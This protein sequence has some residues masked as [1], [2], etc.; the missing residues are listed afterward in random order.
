MFMRKAVLLSLIVLLFPAHLTAETSVVHTGPDGIEFKNNRVSII[1]SG[2]A[3]LVAIKEVASNDDI[4]AHDHAKIASAIT[5]KGQ[6]IY[7]NKAAL[8][9]NTLYLTIGGVS[10]EIEVHAYD[11][12]FTFEVKGTPSSD[13]E[14]LTFLDFRLKYN[15]SA[16]NPLLGAGVALSLQTDPVFFPSGESKEIAGRCTAH[17]GMQGAKLAVIVCR[18][19][20]LRNILKKVYSSLPTLS[21]PF[22]KSGGAFSKDS[23]LNEK[24]CLLIGDSN[25]SNVPQ[26]L[27]FYS[28]LGVGQFDFLPGNKTFIQGDFTFP[29]TGSASEFKRLVANPLY[30]RGIFSSLHTYSFY[31]SYASKEILGNPHWQQQLEQRES[32]SLSKSLTESSGEIEV[33]GNRTALKDNAEYWAVHSPYLLI[34]NEIIKYSIGK[35]GFTSC[36]RGQCGTKASSHSAGSK[37]IV[38]GGNYSHFAPKPGSELFYEI[39][40][41]TARTYNDGGFKG[42]YFDALDGL[43]V[44]LKYAGLEDYRWYYGASFVNEVLKNCNE[45]PQVEYSTLYP[46]IWPAR[47]RGGAWDTPNRGYKNFIDDHIRTNKL[48]IDRHY[49]T[50]LGW[51]DFYPY[52]GGQEGSFSTKYMF[53]DDVDYLGAKSIAY[54]QTMTYNSLKETDVNSIPAMRRNLDAFY[55]Y[56][57]LRVDGYFSESVKTVLRSGKYEYK[58]ARKGG[59]WGFYEAVYCRS[60]LRDINESILVGVNPFKRQKPFI[61]IEN[62]YSSDNRSSRTLLSFNESVDVRNQ[63]CELSFTSPIDLSKHKA[64]RIQLKGNGLES[65]DALCIRLCSSATSGYADYTVRTNFEGWRTVYLTDLDNAENPDLKFVGMDD[66]LY[67]VHR[68]DVNYSKITTI[69][70]FRSGECNGV[71]VKKVEAVPL[72]PNPLTNPTVHHDNTSITFIDTLNSGEYIEYK[73]GNKTAQIYDGIGNART[74]SVERNGR[75][76]IPSGEFELTVSGV[77]GLI[78]APSEVTLTIGLYGGFIRN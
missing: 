47:G 61:R 33:K 42:I 4:A 60:K 24:D 11:D 28:K 36:I 74:V 34:D 49:V 15:F 27:E 67:R 9:G 22:T 45:L 56:N 18:K 35:N 64:L 19:D 77:P 39:A 55:Q 70:V 72:S 62:L 78:D 25:P 40:R 10:T 50:T 30:E 71:K 37:V 7:A 16:P 75:F 68:Y 57:K 2:S 20:D 1:I 63:R 41:R 66:E 73:V 54:D 44:H 46:S 3:E 52:K 51:Y 29:V 8:V 38:L 12:Y 21:V 13:I 48:L 53:F 32:F 76:R 6:T 26:W 43:Y 31:I 23:A 69:Q 5:K 17:I 58:L 59:R 65:H 14:T